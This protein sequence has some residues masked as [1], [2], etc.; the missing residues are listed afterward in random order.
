MLRDNWYVMKRITLVRIMQGILPKREKEKKQV[1]KLLL[2]HGTQFA[3]AVT[4]VFRFIRDYM[5]TLCPLEYTLKRCL[6]A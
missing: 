3:L 1:M 2:L 5:P 4:M 6:L